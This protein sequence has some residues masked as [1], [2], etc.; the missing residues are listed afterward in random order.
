[1]HVGI[2]SLQGESQIVIL[3]MHAALIHKWSMW[4]FLGKDIIPSKFVTT[5]ELWDGQ[6][7]MQGGNDA[8]PSR[9]KKNL[10]KHHSVDLSDSLLETAFP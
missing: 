2:F 7:Y 4:S 3:L 10:M 9:K 8:M 1:M 5:V 6:N